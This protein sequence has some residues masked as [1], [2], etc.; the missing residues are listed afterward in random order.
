MADSIQEQIMK[1]IAAAVAEVTIANGYANTINSV[2]RYNQ[3]G[4][5]LSG[6][7]PTVLIKEGD[8]VTELTKSV[9]GRVRRRMEWY[10]VAI[11][12]QDETSASTDT[13]SGGEMLNSLVADLEQRIGASETWAGLAMFTDPPEYLDIEIDATTPHL[14]KGLRF[15][16]VYEHTRGNPYSQT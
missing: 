9:M 13:R 15:S 6:N 1:K 4:V 12:R 14:A 2:Q 16:T 10:A 8:C 11:T 7:P 3:S 5:N